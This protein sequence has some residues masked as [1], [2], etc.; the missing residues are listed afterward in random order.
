MQLS[1]KA[2]FDS[3]ILAGG[4]GTRLSPLT[5]SIPKPLL[6]VNGEPAFIRNLRMLRKNGFVSTAV[7]TMYLPEKIEE[8]TFHRGY[9]EY[10]RESKPLGSAGAAA[11][12]TDRLEETVLVV[13]GDAV[14]DYDLAEAK[15][16]FEKSGCDA[17]IILCRK[18][19]AGE[20]GSVCLYKGKITQFYE[21]PS[22][23]DTLSDLIN[24]GI[25]FL[26]K[27][28]IKLIPTDKAVDFA[29]DLFPAMLKRGMT[30]AGI[31]PMGQCAN[32]FDIFLEDRF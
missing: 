6:P 19:D 26:S 4:F 12:L 25:Y 3:I 16:Q 31:E 15:K 18:D 24:T 22:V 20:Y 14:W 29:H 30:I 9:T 7:T 21:K 27:R 8:A 17:G 10:F 1:E 32:C 2:S 5:D 13:S 23:R 11:M 28:A